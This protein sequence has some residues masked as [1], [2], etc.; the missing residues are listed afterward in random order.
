M[1]SFR[2]N[3]FENFAIVLQSIK[4][5]KSFQCKAYNQKLFL[6]T[7]FMTYLVA[8]YLPIAA[9]KSCQIVFRLN[10]NY[11][12]CAVLCAMYTVFYIFN[13]LWINYFWYWC[14]CWRCL[15]V[16]FHFNRQLLE[17][18]HKMKLFVLKSLPFYA[19]IH[20]C[21]FILMINYFPHI[22]C[23]CCNPNRILIEREDKL[24]WWHDEIARAVMLKISI[25]YHNRADYNINSKSIFNIST[26]LFQLKRIEKWEAER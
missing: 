11:C 21:A 14:D 26:H 16:D 6:R 12:A 8:T 25:H 22:L 9:E 1:L 20:V 24:W 23:F 2:V 4:W 10:P 13:N 18:K 5:I 7:N 15:W 17:I 19:H 3:V